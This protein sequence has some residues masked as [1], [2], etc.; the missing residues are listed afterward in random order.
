MNLKEAELLLNKHSINLNFGYGSVSESFLIEKAE[1]ISRL[2]DVDWWESLWQA[3]GCS[4]G[5]YSG[6]LDQLLLGLVLNYMNEDSEN[7]GI[8][9]DKSRQNEIEILNYI[10]CSADILE[11]GSSPR[12]PWLTRYGEVVLDLYFNQ[13]KPDWVLEQDGI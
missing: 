9:Y 2:E 11:Y 6:E 4:C 10:M 1:N 7:N 5:G 3:I 13:T 8:F 12:F